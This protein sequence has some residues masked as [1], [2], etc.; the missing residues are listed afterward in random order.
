MRR[1]WAL[2][3][4][5]EDS[6]LAAALPL[7]PPQQVRRGPVALA[8]QDS[9]AQTADSKAIGAFDGVVFNDRQVAEP[10]IGRGAPIRDHA[11]LVLHAVG[12]NG[13]Q[14]LATL[15]WHG[16]LAIVH[17]AQR[18]AIVARDWQG[19]GGL[20]WAPWG[21]GQAFANSRAGLT[22]LG[23]H[24][25][26]VPPGMAAI[27]AA[28]GV[29]WQ[30]MAT[31]AE[32][33]GWFRELPDECAAPTAALWQDGLMQRLSDAV[34]ACQRTYPR[35][36]Q[37]AP[38]DRTGA[39][40]AQHFPI[41]PALAADALW[42]LAGADAWLGLSPAE[43]LP[44]EPGPW[45]PP[46]PAEPLRVGDQE[47]RAR[48]VRATWLADVALETARM[49]ALA[50]D[51]PIVAPHLDPAVLAWLGAMPRELRPVP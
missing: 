50:L 44:P 35:L 20:Y 29:Q 28:S 13:P 42:T 40:L 46:E 7:L 49:R 39:W 18:S 23:L 11:S 12:W 24:S 34:A 5:P 2:L 10:L 51:L 4:H 32:A 25:R 36:Q 19:V 21:A 14:G 15:R 22:G 1:N 48:R 38:S 45:P 37:D 26:L 31:H 41:A 6:E 27:C 3:W 43:P 17:Q 16:T 47:A 9:F 33:R 8:V 30:P